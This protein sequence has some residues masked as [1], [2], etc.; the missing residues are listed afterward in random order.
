M[1]NAVAPSRLGEQ[2]PP[3]RS[4]LRPSG[5]ARFKRGRL[6]HRLLQTLP[7]LDIRDRPQA[8]RRYL[9]QVAGDLGPDQR[10]AIADETLAVL[11]QPDFA[12]LF[13][14]GGQAEVAITGHV[15]ALGADISIAGQVDRLVV[16]NSQVL[17]VDYKTNRP[18]PHRVEDV[19]RP[20]LRQM[21]AYREALRVLYPGLEVR[22]ALL[23]TDG[24]RLM[25]LDDGLL[26][27]ALAEITR[28]AT[29]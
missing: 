23:W 11:A 14:P 7:D 13:G 19:A 9:D 20:Y 6:I 22:C 29:D 3:P 18:P 15:P 4:P 8:A 12:D 2:E 27:Q 16:T 10:Q 24:P 21:A 25:G 5:A 26:D 28:A 1:F 17:I